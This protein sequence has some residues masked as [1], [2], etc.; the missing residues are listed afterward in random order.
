M[1][2]R[3]C[4]KGEGF[5][6]CCFYA[7]KSSLEMTATKWC[8]L[9]TRQGLKLRKKKGF[10][11]ENRAEESPTTPKL[12]EEWMWYQGEGTA[13]WSDGCPCPGWLLVKFSPFWEL[14]Q[15]KDNICISVPSSACGG[16]ELWACRKAQPPPECLGKY[17]ALECVISQ[18][19]GH[20]EDEITQRK[21]WWSS[22]LGSWWVK[23]HSPKQGPFIWYV[24]SLSTSGIFC[25][26]LYMQNFPG[27]ESCRI[28][29]QS[30]GAAGSRAWCTE[31]DSLLPYFSFIEKLQLQVLPG[32]S[33]KE[34]LPK[35]SSF[36]V[37]M[38][39]DFPHLL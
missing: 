29:S 6:R 8:H 18:A 2:N 33:Y 17:W 31:I 23:A 21:E 28:S 7:S 5:Q 25:L 1:Q 36:P 27:V 11:E 20:S 30:P 38:Q 3:S 9:A 12:F 37:V 32:M 15:T 19:G 13:L 10:R 24:W 39:L 26:F 16:G 4:I 22:P 35:G 14:A 34:Q